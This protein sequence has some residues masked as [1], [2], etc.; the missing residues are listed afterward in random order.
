M[1]PCMLDRVPSTARQG[2][3]AGFYGSILPAVW[4]FQLALR[5]RGLG[6]AWTTLHLMFEQDAA[7][8]LA[9]PAEITQTALIPVAHHTGGEFKPAKRLPARDRTYWNTWGTRR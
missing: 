3:M 6:S 1:I 7:R 5:S 4:S 9:I 8:L 2:L